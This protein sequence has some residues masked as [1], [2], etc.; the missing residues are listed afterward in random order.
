MY[1]VTYV[2]TLRNYEVI[3]MFEWTYVAEHLGITLEY[4][5]KW[6]RHKYYHYLADFTIVA[7]S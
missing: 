3:C 2:K 6:F 1:F 5:F 7:S 4:S